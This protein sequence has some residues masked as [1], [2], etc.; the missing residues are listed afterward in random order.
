MTMGDRTPMINVNE[1]EP[2]RLAQRP[3]SK[4]DFDEHDDPYDA[5]P[6]GEMMRGLDVNVFV[7]LSPTFLSPSHQHALPFLTF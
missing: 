5:I 3:S 4:G 6:A 1:E 7:F 2:P